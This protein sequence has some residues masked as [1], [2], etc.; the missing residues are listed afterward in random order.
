MLQT[1]ATHDPLTSLYNRRYFE[2]E[3]TRRI[4][5]QTDDVFSIFMIDADHFKNVNDTYGHKTGDKVL[6]VLSSTAEKA[7]REND[8]LLSR[9][10]S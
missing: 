3:V 7:L 1:Q 10:G 4:S 6:M 8:R 5:A 9:D 2:S